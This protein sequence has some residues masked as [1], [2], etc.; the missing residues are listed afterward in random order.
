MQVYTAAASQ[1][2]VTLTNWERLNYAPLPLGGSSAVQWNDHMFVLAQDCITLLYHT[3]SK[4]WSMLPKSPYTSLSN[5]HPAL[6]LHNDQILTMSKKGQVAAFD[7]RFSDW[8][9]LSDMNMKIQTDYDSQCLLVSYNS[10]L[11]AIVA[12][13]KGIATSLPPSLGTSGLGGGLNVGI[14]LEGSTNMSRIST[15][16]YEQVK[17]RVRKQGV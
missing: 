6:T 4:I 9:E 10:N 2:K 15:G 3:K 12:L 7:P 17:E 8:T 5:A 1:P 13:Q 14:P 16:V 11:Y